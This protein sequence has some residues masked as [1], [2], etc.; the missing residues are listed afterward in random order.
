MLTPPTG[1]TAA[2]SKEDGTKTLAMVDKSIY[3]FTKSTGH[4]QYTG[5]MK[6]PCTCAN[7]FTGLNCETEVNECSSAPCKNSGT[8][9]DEVSGYMCSCASTYTGSTCETKILIEVRNV[10]DSR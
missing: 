6:T 4:W 1:I 2:V 10:T 8:C 5:E 3:L 9:T 7:G